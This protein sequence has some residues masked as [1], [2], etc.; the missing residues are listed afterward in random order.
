VSNG[1]TVRAQF[2][3][4]VKEFSH[5]EPWVMLERQG[6]GLEVFG[7]G[8]LGLELKRGTSLEDAQ[9]VAATLQALVENVSYTNLS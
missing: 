6:E 5:G 2:V 4:A 3:F 9:R 1:R 7:H 8:F